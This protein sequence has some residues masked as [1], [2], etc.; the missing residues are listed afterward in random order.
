MFN[1]LKYMPFY[2]IRCV[3]SICACFWISS[4]TEAQVLSDTVYLNANFV[5]TIDKSHSTYLRYTEFKDLNKMEG[6]TKTFYISGQKQAEYPVGDSFI[7]ASGYSREWYKNGQ[8]KY[9]EQIERNVPVGVSK[10]WYEN[11]QLFYTFSYD[12]G[13]KHGEAFTYYQNGNH[14][15]M[16]VFEKGKLIKGQC[17]TQAGQDTVYYPH[18][19][20]PVFP[21]GLEKLYQYLG[22]NI[23]YPKTAYKQKAQ[24]NVI[25]QFVV[26]KTG[27]IEN[28]EVVRSLH[29]DLDR[30]SVRVTAGMPSWEPGLQEG[31]PVNVRYT[32]P[33]RYKL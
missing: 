31:V 6:T 26:S 13:Y 28:I 14:K 32:L 17:F 1:T 19:Q 29:P 23:K 30:E 33:I 21:G 9:E 2:L 20:H 27:K 10:S 8:L 5:K 3:F 18:E 4:I 24:G 15:R 25:L 12:D 22:K 7:K 16:E 11:G